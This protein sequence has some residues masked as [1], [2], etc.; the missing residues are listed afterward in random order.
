MRTS[1]PVGILGVL[2]AFSLVCVLGCV[3][4]SCAQN[5]LST[6]AG[7]NSFFPSGIL[8]TSSPVGPIQGIAFDSSANPFFSD[9]YH[10]QVFKLS[11]GTLALIAGNGTAG[12][13]GDGQAATAAQL[14]NPVGLAADSAGNL[15]IA[16]S[17]NN[18]IRKVD[19]HG[20]ITTY[21]GN[22]N[23]GLV[24]DGG[25]AT[26]ASLSAPR[27]V[28]VSSAQTVYIADSGN[29]AIRQVTPN[30]VIQTV[31]TGY[32][33]LAIAASPNGALYI[34]TEPVSGSSALLQIN[35][36]PVSTVLVAGTLIGSKNFL[37]SGPAI[38]AGLGTAS[39]LWVNSAG[40]IY[41]A[42]TYMYCI[43]EITPD[44]QIHTLAGS[45]SNTGFGGDGGAATAAQLN[46]PQ[47]VAVDPSG[48]IWIG[49]T[50][51]NRLREVS[52]G[53]INTVAGSGYPYYYGD[54]VPATSAMISSPFYSQ[55]QGMAFDSAGNLYFADTFNDRIRKIDTSGVITT[56]VS[57]STII[58]GTSLT[59][60]W[61][62]E[63]AVDSTGA[64][65]FLMQNHSQVFKLLQDGTVGVVAGG[66]SLTHRGTPWDQGAPATSVQ[67]SFPIS[68]AFDS[69]NNLYIA[70]YQEIDMVSSNG[71]YLTIAGSPYDL[72][73]IA[74]IPWIVPVYLSQVGAILVDQAGNL[75]FA[76]G[77]VLKEIN[78]SGS[79]STLATLPTT[80]TQLAF[81]SA[82]YLY[83]AQY[84]VAL[85]NTNLVSRIAPDGTVATVASGGPSA[86]ADG[87]AAGQANL[88]AHGIALD[89]SGNLYVSGTASNGQGSGYQGGRIWKITQT[90]GCY[91]ALSAPRVTVP[92]TSSTESV[93]VTAG[94]NCSWQASSP[95]S[96]ITANTLSGAGNG[97][98]SYS[99]GSNPHVCSRLG[100]L[101]AAEQL[102]SIT[103]SSSSGP[104]DIVETVAGASSLYGYAGDGGPATGA[105]LNAPTDV[106]LDASG[107][108][109][110]ADSGNN[111]IRIVSPSGVITT[112]AG[113]GVAGFS[114]DNGPASSATFTGP[115]KIVFDSSGNLYLTADNR[116]R[117]IST[118]G[119][120]T[121]VAGNGVAGFAGDGG[122][123]TAA[124]LNNPLGLAFDSAGNLYVA[125]YWNNRIRKITPVGVIS[126][127]VGG[128]NSG[129][130]LFGDGGLA[131]NAALS[132]P[133]DVAVDSSGNLFIAEENDI[134]K[135]LATSGI[136]DTYTA[137]AYATVG[138]LD[139][140][141]VSALYLTII[142][143][144]A[145]SDGFLYV[146]GINQ[147]FKIDSSGTATALVAGAEVGFS[148]GPAIAASVAYP[149]G[150]ILDAAGNLV[151]ADT[152]NARVRK[153][154]KGVSCSFQLSSDQTFL[155]GGGPGTA[156]VTNT[157]DCP[158][159]AVSNSPFITIVQGRSGSGS[160]SVAFAVGIN[161]STAPRTGTITI[162]G[163]TF[164]VNQGPLPVGVFSAAGG[165]GTQGGTVNLPVSMTL[166]NGVSFD[167]L[168][169]T[170]TLLPN[171][172]SLPLTGG[173]GFTAGG[174]MP[175][176]TTIDTSQPNTITVTWSGLSPAMSGARAVGNVTVTLPID[177]DGDHYAVHIAAAS[178]MSGTTFLAFAPSSD[179]S[180]TEPYR[181]YLVGDSY[182]LLNGSNSN[183]LNQF[184]DQL[185]N[186][187]DLISLL[188][189]VTNITGFV[190]PPCTDLF[191]AMDIYPL[192]GTTR[193][194]DGM[195]NTLD[196]V[197]LLRRVTSLDT[198]RPR[199]LPKTTCSPASTPASE[200]RRVRAGALQLGDPVQTA[201]GWRVSIYI[202][203]S[204]AIRLQGLAFAIT[205]DDPGLSWRP[206]NA[207]PPSLMDNGIP[208]NLA[209]AWLQDLNLAAGQPQLLGYVL[210]SGTASP[211][212]HI[213]TVSAHDASGNPL[214]FS[215]GE[216]VP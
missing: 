72:F 116:V 185:L 123:A 88:L 12:F 113:T 94:S 212:L 57:P 15:Y 145:L 216:H 114:G 195:L 118:G 193:G 181:T 76:D 55:N 33:A 182:P 10:H 101:D 202:Q 188:R 34:T 75:Y 119:I 208:G 107:N 81:D 96:W 163:Q 46:L 209:L 139:G 154:A 178:G 164:T 24:G 103:Q 106:A 161:T 171:G 211:Q 126:T 8:A 3:P 159:T 1:I 69:A 157:Q 63:I 206:G 66:G 128:N 131:T 56:V 6:F 196:L 7:T 80:V 147:I 48:N 115:A 214:R 73:G 190:P 52:A 158:W 64:V 203:V 210:S 207:G 26:N 156:T 173:L 90:P 146:T 58:T 167:T 198:S 151:F 160:G 189:A 62:T 175:T 192:D 68:I 22:G 59:V 28:T 20:V 2:P 144:R 127:A 179:A 54:G 29:G 194:G 65:Y 21:A 177:G 38:N 53:I 82:G 50:G 79:I 135:V 162:G 197:A 152:G 153:I 84:T 47:A 43:Q 110:I 130:A 166:D 174:G 78:S 176:P 136:I 99:V 13:S 27:S 172:S 37:N 138:C 67:L 155:S 61:P 11:A 85:P 205:S 83:A 40:N 215:S 17:G 23:P 141:P 134:R 104:P 45:F 49:D 97:S 77:D 137:R 111:R 60:H 191:D 125:D 25:Q 51:N 41:I 92:G 183:S 35:L 201:S 122:P 105:L 5:T 32:A 170:L 4:P 184:G 109:Y 149:R 42:N 14:N 132:Y 39:G 124:S 9:A 187:L 148:G 87:M 121:T 150:T 74:N 19:T 180:L 199:R 129:I 16:D 213:L 143:L 108:L 120:I 102:V 133:T 93:G 204:S 91:Y 30:G 98:V 186:T 71:Q 44:G 95:T 89:S 169:F 36:A 142:S 31:V 140:E 112:F 165:S 70:Q 200:S 168:S 100:Y 18:R 117:K 86:P